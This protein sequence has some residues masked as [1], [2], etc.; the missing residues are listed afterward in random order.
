MTK[1]KNLNICIAI[2]EVCVIIRITKIFN[3]Q[4]GDNVIE[5]EMVP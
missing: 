5:E 2:Y 3:S 4:E 1:K